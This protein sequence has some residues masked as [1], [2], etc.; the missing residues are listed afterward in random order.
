MAKI[1]IHEVGL[2][3]GLQMEEKTVPTSKK[4]QWVKELIESGFKIIQVGSFVHPKYVPQMADTDELFKQIYNQIKL[5]D[6]VT[7]SALVLNEKGVE[8]GFNCNVQMFCMGVS[9]SETHSKKNTNMS[10]DEALERINAMGENVL[11]EGKNVQVSVQSAFGCGYEGKVAVKQVL[12]IV[13]AYLK[14]GFK[15]ISLADTAG[16]ATPRDVENMFTAIHKMDANVELTCHFHNT[17]GM[18]L[19]NCYAAYQSGVS[20]FEAAFGGLGGCPF[21]KIAGGNVC[22]EDLVHMFQKMG[23]VQE[24][25]LPQI[26]SIARDSEQ[27][28]H[29]ELPGM[30]YKVMEAV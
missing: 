20:Y 6:D 30:I 16:H 12:R 14:K 5:P 2:R 7:L 1:V 25:N 27:V 17:Y 24:I 15:K 29:H 11:N 21:T 18:G 4:L 9:A 3:D 26:V 23:L 28:L 22:T 13:D 8:R 19:A 10:V